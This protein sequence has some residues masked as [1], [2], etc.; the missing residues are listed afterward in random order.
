MDVPFP[1]HS[2]LALLPACLGPPSH[3]AESER[4][5]GGCGISLWVAVVWVAV[6]WVER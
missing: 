3:S 2:A 5:V 1:W 6:V 4:A